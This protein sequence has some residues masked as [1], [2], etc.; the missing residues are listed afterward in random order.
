MPA[1]RDIMLL[2]CI[3]AGG[4]AATA[5]CC[6]LSSPTAARGQRRGARLLSTTMAAVAAKAPPTPSAEVVVVNYN[7]LAKSLG[8]NCIPWV[9]SVSPELRQRVEMQT[10]RA[11]IEWKADTLASA[12]KSHF[13]KNYSS[14]DYATMRGLWSARLDS[15]ADLPAALNGLTFVGP[16]R[17]SYRPD[18]GEVVVAIT[19]HGV[20]LEALPQ[21][22][23]TDLF[24]HLMAAEEGIY[25]WAIRGP[26]IFHACT[27]PA[28][29]SGGGSCGFADLIALEEYDCHEAVAKY[30][31]GHGE[32][33]FCEAMTAAGY[34]GVLFKDPVL[35]K[36]PFSG[37]AIYWRRG[38]FELP[39]SVTDSVNGCQVLECGDTE[40]CVC[41]FDLGEHWHPQP[42]STDSG[43]NGAALMKTVDRRN[44]GMVHLRHCASGSSIHCIA[45]HLMTKSRDGRQ[46]NQYPGEVRSAELA[47]IRRLLLQNDRVGPRD[48]VLFMGDLNTQPTERHVFA[49]VVPKASRAGESLTTTTSD[50][51]RFETGLDLAPELRDIV[52]LNWL[53]QPG[54][55]SLR[56]AFEDVHQWGKEPAM[57]ACCTSMNA[58][59]T[60]WIDYMFH[61]P[62][63]LQVL[64]RGSTEIP[65]SPIPNTEHGSDHL[66]LAARFAIL[67]A[68]HRL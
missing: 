46:T 45:A 51:I 66:P 48:G 20:L 22:L 32:E 3:A 35:G 55:P 64:A 30:R 23:A 27:Q 31:D 61:T 6:A 56:C 2:P 57:Q 42:K 26:R 10:G 68:T 14:G 11:W 65:A 47:T 58:A 15:V 29:C 44:V 39:S 63:A 13:H 41:N 24:E 18:E 36:T 59:R 38:V 49:G 53:P 21:P 7:I 17:V 62:D 33:T 40:A 5:V 1:I 4:A 8:S 37:L 67:D 28:L 50:T 9:M 43:A 34:D 60:E 52:A 12:Y 25:S 16:D 19:L 54:R